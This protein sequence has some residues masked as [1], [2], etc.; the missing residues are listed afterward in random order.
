M[1]QKSQNN[2]RLDVENTVNNHLVG[3]SKN[4]NYNR[5]F[6]RCFFELLEPQEVT[7]HPKGGT[8]KTNKSTLKTSHHKLKT[9][10]KLGLDGI[11]AE[12]RAPGGRLFLC[13]FFRNLVP[14]KTC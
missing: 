4:K 2:H 8:K 14:G 6:R 11:M 7:L 1:V 9:Q 5:H 12:E 13:V 3:A 10:Q